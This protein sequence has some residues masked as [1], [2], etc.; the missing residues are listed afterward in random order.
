[1]AK[2]ALTVA[3]SDTSGGAGIQADLKVFEEHGVFGTTALTSIV[4]YDPARGFVH[5]IDFV[6]A[7][8]I[9]KQLES[10]F[11]MHA[12]DG[13]KS[14]ML[15]TP[16]AVTLL[17][18]ALRKAGAGVPYVLD[19]VLVCKGQGAMVDLRR[20]FVE[21]LVPLATVMTPNLEEAAQLTG[22]EGLGDVADMKRAA[23]ALHGLGAEA[24]LVKGGARL[25][26]DD[27]VDVLYDGSGF[28]VFRTPKLGELMVNGAGCSLAAA[29]TSELALGS[30]VATAVERAKTFV[31]HAI[32]G[33]LPNA[34]GVDSVWHAA[35]RLSPSPDVAVRR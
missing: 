32:A 34:T 9:A 24:V 23:E 15:G 35:A 30:D 14:G 11:A 21:E 27:A 3:G 25:A 2:R 4:S 28:T 26:G 6:D 8:V 5:D 29:I 33:H 19:P 7:E 22:V 12:F 1:M 31:A 16:E 13:V 20:S 18:A 10:A 17:A